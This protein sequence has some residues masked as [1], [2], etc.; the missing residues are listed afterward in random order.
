MGCQTT[1]RNGGEVSPPRH[2]SCISS[3][4]QS[5]NDAAPRDFVQ[6]T[7]EPRSSPERHSGV[8]WN[9]HGVG[10]VT[11]QGEPM[12]DVGRGAGSNRSADN[13]KPGLQALS[14]GVPLV[15]YATALRER[16]AITTGDG[17]RSL[18]EPLAVQ[19]PIGRYPKARSTPPGHFFIGTGRTPPAS[20]LPGLAA[21]RRC[22]RNGF[23]D[24]LKAHYNRAAVWAVARS[25]G[26][27]G[28]CRRCL[29][30]CY[31]RGRGGPPREKPE[32][33]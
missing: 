14:P 27:T 6:P 26:T 1:R 11:M 29:V 10:G 31:D 19:S 13:K 16:C 8:T 33:S 7:C 12:K 32:A 9:R 3:F 2:R 15:E 28:V 21:R 25:G 5:E 20:E 22:V 23:A 24:D 4:S 17:R 18:H 30:G